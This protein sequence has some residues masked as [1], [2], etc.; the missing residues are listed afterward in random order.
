MV[1]LTITVDGCSDQ[2]LIGTWKGPVPLPNQTKIHSL[3]KA[4]IGDDK[5]DF[6]DF[7]TSMLC[8]LPEERPTPSQ[9]Y[10]HRWL[11]GRDTKQSIC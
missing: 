5:D 11:R 8:W 7:I 3:A 2:S 1:C 6:L 10:L 4:L 9:A